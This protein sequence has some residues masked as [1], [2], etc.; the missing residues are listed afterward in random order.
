MNKCHVNLSQDL[1][2][3]YTGAVEV[4]IEISTIVR[5]FTD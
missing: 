3:D 4:S 2:L 1:F 5:L